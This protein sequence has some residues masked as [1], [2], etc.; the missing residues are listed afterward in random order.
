[1]TKRTMESLKK[2]GIT[3]EQICYSEGKNPQYIIKKNFSHLAKRNGKIKEIY[4]YSIV[5]Q[6]MDCFSKSRY[7]EYYY[8]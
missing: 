1:M 8:G 6:N 4:K 3:P 7:V 2:M 5:F